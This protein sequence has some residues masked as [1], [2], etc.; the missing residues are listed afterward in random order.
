[1]PAPRT[2][3]NPDAMAAAHD[4]ARSRA[5]QMLAPEGVDPNEGGEDVSA[6]QEIPPEGAGDLT[7]QEP[8]NPAPSLESLVDLKHGYQPGAEEE[9]PNGG[10]LMAM[11]QQMLQEQG[12]N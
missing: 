12:Q 6:G 1:M 4:E 2:R 3:M 10:A 7:G 9:A 5:A 11:V 8:A